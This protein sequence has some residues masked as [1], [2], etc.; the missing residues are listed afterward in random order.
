MKSLKQQLLEFAARKAI[1]KAID[2]AA[3]EGIGVAKKSLR[4]RR[5]AARLN[6]NNVPTHV[7][8]R[9]Y[10]NM[11]FTEAAT[12]AGNQTQEPRNRGNQR[13]SRDEPVELWVNTV[14]VKSDGGEPTRILTGRPMRAFNDERD[15]TTN[16]EEFNRDNAMNN[17]FVRMMRADADA[18]GLGETK[19]YGPGV[20]IDKDGNPTFKAGIYFELRREMRDRAQDAAAKADIEASAESELRD[21]FG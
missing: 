1:S 17:A 5:G 8:P 15:V 2:V 4:A 6:D 13:Y 16:N 7:N 9:K 10:H 19:Y 11:S 18:L 20:T 12:F 14:I 21:I 3:Y